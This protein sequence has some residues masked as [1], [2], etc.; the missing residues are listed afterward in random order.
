MNWM[1]ASIPLADLADPVALA[2]PFFVLAIAAE[3]LWTRRRRLTCRYETRDAAAS[4]ITG[5]VSTVISAGCTSRSRSTG[6]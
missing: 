2:V 5:L 4:L 6:S 1:F 3:M